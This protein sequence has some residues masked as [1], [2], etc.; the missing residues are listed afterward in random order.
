MVLI[1]HLPFETLQH[2]FGYMHPKDLG[3]LLRTCKCFHALVA[4]NKSL[5]RTI[6]YREL[7]WH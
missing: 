3:T 5:H 6:Y 7:V 1:T 4:G 2:V